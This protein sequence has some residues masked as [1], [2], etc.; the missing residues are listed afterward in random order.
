MSVVFG[1]PWHDPAV[2]PGLVLKFLTHEETGAIAAAPTTS[3]PEDI[4]GVRNW[5]YRFSW[6]RDAAF[7]LQALANLGHTEEAWSYFDW[8]LGLCHVENPKQIQPL[9]SLHAKATSV[10]R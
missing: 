5:D 1:G 6:S 4:G 10:K 8:F 9:Y 2:R 7:T 3:L